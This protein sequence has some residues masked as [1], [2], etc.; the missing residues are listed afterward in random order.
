M[1]RTLGLGLAVVVQL[2]ACS[3][4]APPASSNFPSMGAGSGVVAPSGTAGTAAPAP[5]PGAAGTGTG[6]VT[7]PGGASG[8]AG[9]SVAPT[10]TAGTMAAT[11]AGT[12]AATTAGTGAMAGAGAA[13]S[14]SMA[15]A[16]TGSAAGSGS[17]MAGTG[18][19]E[20]GT[21]G[22]EAGTGAPA[23]GFQPKCI[24]KGAEL[25]LVGDSWINYTEQLAPRLAQRAIADKALMRG[26]SY[27]DQ[28]VPGTSL[29]GGGLGLIRDQ[30]PSAKTAAQRAGTS[31]KFVVMDGGGNDVLLGAPQCLGDGSQNDAGCQRVVADATMA[32]MMLQQRMVADGVTQGVYF[33]YPHV[34]AGGADILDYSL[35][36]AKATCEGMNS[37]KYQCYFLD[38]REAFQGPGNNGLAM[39]Q[40]IGLDG[41][42]PTAAGDDLLADLVW[43]LMKDHCMAQ[44]A[45][46]GGGCCTP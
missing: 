23:S 4:D 28:S 37:D 24:A 36:M 25:A 16:G 14:D 35:P 32:G 13:G 7:S 26:D 34:P 30:W 19:P 41:I 9:T 17:S 46:S 21:G 1:K 42:H 20:A 33:F 8:T 29:A 18:G 22:G 6:V 2:V 10:S 43:K 5:S 45:E 44:T 39:G 38:T 12:M 27:N 15:M 3:N 40:Y 11:T 31:V